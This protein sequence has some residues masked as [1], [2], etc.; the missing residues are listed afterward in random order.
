MKQYQHKNNT[1]KNNK[2]YVII[3]KVNSF[4]E[5]QEMVDP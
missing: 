1:S 5:P 2:G 3:S 4:Y